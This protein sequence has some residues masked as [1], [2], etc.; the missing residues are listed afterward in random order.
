[1]TRDFASLDPDAPST[2]PL[3]KQGRLGRRVHPHIEIKIVDPASAAIVPRG[4]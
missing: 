3:E 4:T 1:M 2:I